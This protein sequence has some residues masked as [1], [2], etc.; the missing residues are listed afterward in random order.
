MLY[1]TRRTIHSVKER[2]KKS[3][4]NRKEKYS[5]LILVSTM[6]GC[7]YFSFLSDMNPR[8]HPISIAFQINVN[9]HR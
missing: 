3:E 6:F 2:H 4:K 8:S 7:F 5:L 9:T 1:T